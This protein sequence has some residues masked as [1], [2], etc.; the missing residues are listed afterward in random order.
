MNNNLEMI[1]KVYQAFAAGDIPAVLARLSPTV[2]WTEAQGGPYGGVYVGPESVLDNV[3]KKL[4]G[5]W[6]GFTAVP[7][8]FVA[9][10]STVV[11]LGEYSATYKATGKSFKAP[12]A[13]VWKIDDDKVTSFQ[14][15]T[16][17]A[18]HLEPLKA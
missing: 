1:R 18:V 12:Y 11:V 15:Y 8:Q 3:F 13:H 4:G 9:D 2:Q 5:E 6:D 14:Q 7:E 10:G 16:D 17:T